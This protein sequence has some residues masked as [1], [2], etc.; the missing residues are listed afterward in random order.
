MEEIYWVQMKEK[1]ND[2]SKDRSME[3][4]EAQCILDSVS[5]K[6][7]SGIDISWRIYLDI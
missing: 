7:N 4:G 5:W 1:F 6:R 3:I 2:F